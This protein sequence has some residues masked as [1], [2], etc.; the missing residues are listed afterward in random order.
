MRALKPLVVG[1]FEA[2][3]LVL[4]GFASMSL[5]AQRFLVELALGVLFIYR[6]RHCAV[7]TIGTAKIS[8]Y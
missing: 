8:L 4:V 1:H 2:V 3:V 5:T 7:P 6:V